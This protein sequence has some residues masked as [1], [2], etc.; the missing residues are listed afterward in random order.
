MS[1]TGKE[2]TLYPAL[3]LV[4]FTML[5]VTSVYELV[6]QLLNPSITIWESH[7]ITIIFTSFVAL[8]VVYLP[9]RSFYN[10]RRK[11]EQALQLRKEAEENLR[12]SEIQYRSFVESAEDSIY[13]VD[14]E[15][16]Y[17]LI[18]TRH[19]VRSRGIP[20]V[21]IGKTYGEFH[22]PAETRIFEE[23]VKKVIDGKIPVLDEY[24]RD[25]RYFFRKLNPVI[26]PIINDVIAITVISS[27][28]TGRKQA[29]K[30]LA[31]T[32]RKLN[33]MN[34]VT[35]HDILN[36]L[37]ALNSLLALANE[38]TGEPATKKYLLKSGQIADTI[39]NQILFARDYQKI[40][41]ESPQWQNI[42]ATIKKAFLLLKIEAVAI[43]ESCRD[44]EIF[45]DPLLEKVF[46]NLMEN[47]V[48]YAGPHPKIRFSVIREPERLLLTCE[49][50]GPGI[51]TENK[52][53]I[54][55]RGFGKNTGLGLFLIREILSMT[56]ITISENG[57]EGKGSR[58]EISIPT[59]AF[60]I[61]I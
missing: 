35:R 45:A 22:S 16:R 13:T 11:A 38:Q 51:P 32:N 59:E 43:D 4:F 54:F 37:T 29:E 41:V 6:K 48:R 18:N 47:A 58:F 17:L 21:Y 3:A 36:Q 57:N 46:Y 33:L 5:I 56:E 20:Q 61:A 39:Q 1:E 19:L 14:R 24:E 8:I 49:D 55:Q 25:G 9:L 15:C 30:N 52:E 53:K 28:I 44:Y 31:T 27:D 34:D 12:R 23:Q 10:E 26:D 2:R 60:R 50:D 42:H 40:G 7:A